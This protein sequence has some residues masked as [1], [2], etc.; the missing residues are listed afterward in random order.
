VSK[1]REEEEKMMAKSNYLGA[2]AAAAGTL[3]AVGLL[4]LMLVVVDSR[5][6]GA[7]VPQK[8][9]KSSTKPQSGVA[10]VLGNA[11][12]ARI[13][14]RN[15][16]YRFSKTR[17][18]A[19]LRKVTITARISE[20]DTARGEFDHNDL[21]LALDNINTGIALN[22][23]RT[24]HTDKRTIS[25]VPNHRTALKAALKKDGKLGARIID[26]D[27]ADKGGNGVAIPA[28]F[29]TTLRIRGTLTR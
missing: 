27:P 26:A 7:A 24:G 23:F 6:A 12:G 14:A 16:P 19:R 1:E 2:L 10:L 15:H 11:N 28:K 13:T 5:S 4:V 18:I 8:F 25:G 17:R 22:G 20:G 29:K 21:L 9:T 3:A